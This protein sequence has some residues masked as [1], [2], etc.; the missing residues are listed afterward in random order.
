[1]TFLNLIIGGLAVWRLSH[2]LV[3]ESGPLMIFARLR[4]FAARHQKRS[5]GLFDMLSCVYCTS[6]WI[7][8][9]VGLYGATDVFHWIGYALAMSAISTILM[10]ALNKLDSLTVVT[11]PTTNNKVSV[12]V[13]SPPEKR[14][15]VVS[16]P[17]TPNGH[18]TVETPPHLNN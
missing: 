12:G 11:T 18:S 16:N 1:M 15:D 17:D 3:K 2:A 10:V 14:D 6:F 4:A 8:L 9:L 13:S 5:G 7:A